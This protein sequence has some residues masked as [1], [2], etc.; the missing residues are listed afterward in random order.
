MSSTLSCIKREVG[1]KQV[2]DCRLISDGKKIGEWKVTDVEVISEEGKEISSEIESTLTSFL[3][4]TDDYFE[5][6]EE[7]DKLICKGSVTYKEVEKR[8]FWERLLGD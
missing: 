4:T 3:A 8:G 5:C 6:N 7:N 2:Y 1:V